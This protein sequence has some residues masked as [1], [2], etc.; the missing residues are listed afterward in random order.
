[1]SVLRTS[2]APGQTDNFYGFLSLHEG[3]IE[4]DRNQRLMR[5]V[6]AVRDAVS[7]RA[8]GVLVPNS[9]LDLPCELA[10]GL[11]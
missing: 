4:S 7:G 9:C 6:W 3:S 5:G 10:P 11:G 8:A 2:G 1:M